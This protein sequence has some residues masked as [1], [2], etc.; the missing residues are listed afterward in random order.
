MA[1]V[2]PLLPRHQRSNIAVR[3]DMAAS[4][5]QLT[6]WLKFN[7][8]KKILADPSA[9]DSFSLEVRRIPE[10]GTLR[11]SQ[12]Y[13]AKRADRVASLN[14]YYP[15]SRLIHISREE[16]LVKIKRRRKLS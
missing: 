9:A 16:A 3:R 5:T 10:K 12:G 6:R 2:K 4:S 8:Y 14:N 1:M 7:F 11:L 15:I 13:R